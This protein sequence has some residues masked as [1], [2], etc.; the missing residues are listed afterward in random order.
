MFIRMLLVALFLNVS[1][2]CEAVTF[3]E[4]SRKDVFFFDY[5]KLVFNHELIIQEMLMHYYESANIELV[6]VTVEDLQG[7][8]LNIYTAE[9]FR[10]WEIGKAKNGRGILILLALKQ[11][12]VRMEVSYALEEVFTDQY[13]SLLEHQYIE[14]SLDSGRA[15]AALQGTIE[16][17]VNFT[18]ENIDNG[19]LSK[20]PAQSSPSKENTSGGAGAKKKINIGMNS[21]KRVI[22]DAE[23]RA[24]FCAQP[25]PDAAMRVYLELLKRKITDATLEIYTEGTRIAME[26]LPPRNTSQFEV[27]A[28]EFEAGLPYHIFVEGDKA[29]VKFEKSAKKSRPYILRKSS[30]GWQV[31]LA[32][33]QRI[34]YFDHDNHWH[35]TSKDHEFMFA[36]NGDRENWYY[37]NP[38]YKIP[39]RKFRGTLKEEMAFYHQKIQEDPHNPVPYLYL[40]E[41]YYYECFNPPEALGYYEQGLARIEDPIFL[42]NLHYYVGNLYSVNSHQ[43]EGNHHFEAYIQVYPN[44]AKGYYRVA[45]NC[46]NIRRF[47]EAIENFQKAWEINPS[48]N[49]YAALSGQVRVYA[50]K[51]D[52]SK[53]EK[54]LKQLKKMKISDARI[55]YLESF[56]DREKKRRLIN[57]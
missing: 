48:E 39:S 13:C 28:R 42:A 33:T 41:L 53:A 4:R 50:L 21:R 55:K 18:W 29:V 7:L 22:L 11:K 47:D 19:S 5:A 30:E 14:P 54:Y 35:L 40:G 38:E 27:T 1:L 34:F 36:F 56:I 57:R 45:Y 15:G 9:L 17:I 3:P 43:L 32:N 2:L 49:N 8:K 26:G 16:N 24:F 20:D 31:D 46:E 51:N 23:D 37:A 10:E 52:F 44:D 25:T 6:I 12:K